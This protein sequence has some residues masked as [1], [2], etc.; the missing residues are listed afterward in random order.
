M[1]VQDMQLRY[2]LGNGRC[3]TEGSVGAGQDGSGARAPPL[4]TLPWHYT[5]SF[6]GQVWL[7]VAPDVPTN[8]LDPTL[9]HNFVGITNTLP[10]S[11]HHDPL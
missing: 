3:S 5:E 9:I 1:L 6:V 2:E 7:S 4:Q 8:P 11:P 10:V